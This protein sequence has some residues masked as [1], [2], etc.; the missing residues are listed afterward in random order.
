MNK[1][2]GRTHDNTWDDKMTVD[3]DKIDGVTIRR[4][5]EEV[6]RDRDQGNP[7]YYNR[8]HNRHNRS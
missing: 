4:L 7:H 3:L 6:R 5:V 2:K 1:L 8:I